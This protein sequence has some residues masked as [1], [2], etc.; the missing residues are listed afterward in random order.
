MLDV[1]DSDLVQDVKDRMHLHGNTFKRFL[2]QRRQFIVA[3]HVFCNLDLSQV[4]SE[5]STF[6]HQINKH[7]VVFFPECGRC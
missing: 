2:L 1:K 6:G 4:I 3:S 7:A 5:P